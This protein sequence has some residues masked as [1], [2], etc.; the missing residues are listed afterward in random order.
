MRVVVDVTPAVLVLELNEL[1]PPLLDRFMAAGDL[2]NFTR[3]RSESIV[4]VTDANEPQE[5]LNPW[6][7]WVTAHTGVGFRE[8]GVFKLGEGANLTFPT[9]ADAVG[10]AGGSVWLCGPMNVVPT[11]AVRGRWLPDPWNPNDEAGSPEL[12][13]F[14]G[15]VR[16]NVQEHTNRSHRLSP[17]AYG[18]F[19]AFM[20]RHGLSL[21]TI[22]ATAGQLLG[23][24]TGRRARWRRAALLDRFQWDLFAF[25]LRRHRPAF[26]TYFSNTTAHYQHVYWRYMDPDVFDIKPSEEE[27]G[28]YG[29]AIR[30]GYR[31]MDRIVGQAMDLA[32]ADTTLVLCTAIS[33]QPYLLKEEE[34]GSRFYR[35]HDIAGLVGRL[36]LH[37]VTK[38]APVMSAQF[39]VFFA[40]ESDATVAEAVLAGAT[41]G[42]RSAFS[43][44]RVGTD[45]FTGLAWTDDLPEDA[46]IDVPAAGV[47][48]RLH[49][50]FYRAETPKSGYHHRE[51]ALWIRTPERIGVEVAERVSLRSVAPTL[52]RLLG[53]ESP[54]TMQAPPLAT[55]AARLG[56]G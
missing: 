19:L 40:E 25:E 49:E 4:Y 16:A 52:L 32:G 12:A 22:Q 45:V 38:V 50:E 55:D 53:L 2:P 54:P 24:R 20:I 18:R 37:G 47:R 14:M 56:G 46:V 10:D 34:G 35:P 26:A 23:E 15:F 42:A 39:H 8:H 30:F 31:E 48:I 43:V 21:S 41:I 17:A 11:K 33:Q 29:D 13:H 28:R 51:G 1:C 9:V 5:H 3:L 7:Q 6:V 27:R 44:R 36:R